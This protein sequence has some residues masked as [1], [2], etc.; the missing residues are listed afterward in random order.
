M[1]DTCSV[2]QFCLSWVRCFTEQSRINVDL[3]YPYSDGCY[4]D[5]C[6]TRWWPNLE[7]CV[8]QPAKKTTAVKVSTLWSL[9]ACVSSVIERRKPDRKISFLIQT[10]IIS[11]EQWIEV[12][13]FL[14][15]V[16]WSPGTGSDELS[17][18]RS[19]TQADD[20][21]CLMFS[22][23]N[24]L[25]PAILNFLIQKKSKILQQFIKSNKE[26]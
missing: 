26:Q 8:C 1:W 25:G 12:M 22:N 23:D 14:T 3:R 10:D 18:L 13:R 6:I 21:V 19:A 11:D 7:M 9:L 5:R 2:S 20:V 4:K 17:P 16:F 15:G 24:Y